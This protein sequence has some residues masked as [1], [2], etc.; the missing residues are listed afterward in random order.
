MFDDLIGIPFRFGGRS[1]E[2]M[3]CW[4]L[5]IEVYRRL[6]IAVE[7]VDDYSDLSAEQVSP[8][9]ADACADRWHRIDEPFESYDVLIF[10][11]TAC[12]AATHCGVWVGNGRI[13]HAV[14]GIGVINSPFRGLRAK[15][16]GAYRRGRAPCPA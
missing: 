3:D 11:I 6:G 1:R 12:G 10:D 7:D 2:G 13:L 4:G 16:L 5:V 9:L 15:L 8:G 14:R